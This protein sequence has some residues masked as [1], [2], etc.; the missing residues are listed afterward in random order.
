V[1]ITVRYA[2]SFDKLRVSG[3]QGAQELDGPSLLTRSAMLGQVRGHHQ[4]RNPPRTSETRND[5][6]CGDHMHN[7]VATAVLRQ[8]V[9]GD[10][11]V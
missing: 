9:L 6:R 3:P 8:Q 11:C 1:T 2:V 4:S 10:H 7:D 5:V